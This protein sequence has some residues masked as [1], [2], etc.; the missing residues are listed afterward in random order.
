[1]TAQ[2]KRMNEIIDLLN[3]ASFVYEQ[4][5]DEVMSN[6]KYDAL[7]DELVLLEESTGIILG[8]SPTQKV[9][10]EVVSNLPKVKH[11]SKMLSL[12]KTKDVNE[13]EKF[14]GDK[15]GLLSWKLD[16]LTVVLTYENGKLVSA[17]T[18]GNGEVGEDITHNARHFKNV[19]KIIGY[20]ERLVLRGEALISYDTFNE[21]NSKLSPEEQYKNP[22]NLASGTV[23]QLDS[24]V[25]SKRNVEW[26][27]FGVIEGLNDT[28]KKAQQFTRLCDLGFVTVPLY[29]VDKDNFEITMDIMKPD[30]YSYPVDGLVLTYNDIDYSNSLGN[31]SHHPLHSIA[32]KWQDETYETT[33][34]DVEWNV[35]RTGV[36]TP[37]AIFEPV[38]IE[39]S[40]V[41]RASVHNL[42]ILNELELGI[43]DTITVYKANMIIPQIDDN[44]TRSKNI[45][46]PQKCPCCGQKTTIFRQ[47]STFLMCENTN[48]GQKLLAKFTHFV[49]RDC[50]NIKGMSEATLELFINKGWI[51]DFSDLYTNV[52]M[53]CKLEQEKGWKSKSIQNLMGAISESRKCTLSQFIASLGIE[54]VGNSQAKEIAKW[55]KDFHNFIDCEYERFLKIDGIGEITA[56]SLVEYIKENRDLLE[57]LNNELDIEPY[58]EQ[59]TKTT[60]SIT[61]KTFVI[62]GTVNHYKNRNELQAEIES[63]GGKV[64]GSVSKS[65][66]YL[67]NNDVESTSG[68][69]KKAHELGVKIISEEEYIKLKE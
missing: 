45:K 22:R 8:D 12:N 13:L 19:P 58:V 63:L 1:M 32:F 10:Y 17:I 18:R 49:S 54:G 47:K 7:Y 38:D 44:L 31:T 15:V 51:K 34:L 3:H 33:L 24:K 46:I 62:T 20:K 40:T 25:C 2:E 48:C 21:I 16:G 60:N 39:G 41:E 64:T 36:I 50:M 56:M 66:D 59:V 11:S 30:T 23:R 28:N 14:L 67:I 35:G 43:G 65:T 29:M 53:W 52:D 37:T 61:G 69:N 68:K 5:K 55:T 42:D 27:C 57:K 9:G 6:K 26:I 4:G